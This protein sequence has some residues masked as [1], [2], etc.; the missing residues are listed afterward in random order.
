MKTD[1]FSQAVTTQRNGR[2]RMQRMIKTELRYGSKSKY[3]QHKRK[4]DILP[5]EK[6][7]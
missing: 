3:Y 1:T 7:K 4:K 6:V 2:Q 5:T